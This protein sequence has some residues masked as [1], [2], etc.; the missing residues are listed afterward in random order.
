MHLHLTLT[1]AVFG[2]MDQWL[3]HLLIRFILKFRL[4][5]LIVSQMVLTR[6]DDL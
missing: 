4:V 1:E 2:Q 5:E 6:V 3:V